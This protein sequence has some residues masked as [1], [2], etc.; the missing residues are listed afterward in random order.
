MRKNRR[1]FFFSCSAFAAGPGSGQSFCLPAQAF[2]C[3]VG[4]L[5]AEQLAVSKKHSLLLEDVG[6]NLF[7]VFFGQMRRAEK[8]QANEIYLGKALSRDSAVKRI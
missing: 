5:R 1:I 2:P 6:D 4:G 8:T 3:V 7:A